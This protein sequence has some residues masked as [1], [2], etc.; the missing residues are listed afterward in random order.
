MYQLSRLLHDQLRSL[1]DHLESHEVTP[2]LFAAPWFLTLFAS[3]FPMSFV[4]RV[5]GKHY[6]SVFFRI[7]FY[8]ST[9]FYFILFLM[10]YFL[11]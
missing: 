4:C 1:H 8:F 5:F 9:V 7:M 10:L 6:I 11:G 2:Q 3:Q